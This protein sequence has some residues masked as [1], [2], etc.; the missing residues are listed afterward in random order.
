MLMPIRRLLIF[1]PFFFIFTVSLF[2]AFQY[3]YQI[4]NTL[5]YASRPLWD[6][7][8]GP[9]E[10]L[11]H[12]YSEGLSMESHTCTLHGWSKRRD[13]SN[14]KVLDAILMSTE[15]DLLEI[16]LN[17]LDSVVDYFLIVESNATFTGLS[18]EAYF[19][20][21]KARF[22]KFEHKIIYKLCVFFLRLRVV[23]N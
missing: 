9:N 15:L 21:N 2:Y 7:D 8:E 22:T 14:V 10:I 16:R 1:V 19:G 3:Q 20:K 17:E 18:K 23:F 4:R 13:E 6:T 12:F 11:P 5:S